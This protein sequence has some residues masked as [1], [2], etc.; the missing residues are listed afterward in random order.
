MEINLHHIQRTE[1]V[2]IHIKLNILSLYQ[3]FY[4]K[5]VHNIKYFDHLNTYYF[6]YLAS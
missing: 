4:T 5:G 3:N 1:L 2:F 6:S